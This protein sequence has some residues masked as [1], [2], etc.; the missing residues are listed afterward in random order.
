MPKAP[1]INPKARKAFSGMA[2]AM[3]QSAGAGRFTALMKL[4][5]AM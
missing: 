4:R 5:N 2:A 1:L 3:T